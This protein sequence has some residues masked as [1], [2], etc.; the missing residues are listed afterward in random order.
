MSWAIKNRMSRFIKPKT[1]HTVILAVDHGY[2]LGPT[3]RLENPAKTIEPLIPYS[4]A[5]FITRGVVRN[6]IDP[7]TSPPIVLRVSGGSTILRDISNESIVTDIEE[8]LRLN[9][10]AVGI[11]VFVGSENERQTLMNLASY[12]N[13]AEGYGMPV[14]AVTAVGKEMNRD[15]RYLA[16]ACRTAAELGASFVKTYHCDNFEKVV[17]GCPV[18]LVMA[19]GKKMDTE[20]D[21]FKTIYNGMQAGAIG[22]DMGR[23]IWQ[24]DHPIPM[25]KAMR[26]I[27]HGKATVQEAL[28]I[29]EKAKTGN[30][31]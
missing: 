19:G 26:S 7:R 12:V 17:E 11:S 28:D 1:G 6:C 5:L 30:N 18:P 24:H 10:A 27:V 2:F 14:M 3:T 20:K 16:L 23:N 9:A 29:F 31:E 21:V 4:D 13:E 8:A 22:V 25:I 15:A